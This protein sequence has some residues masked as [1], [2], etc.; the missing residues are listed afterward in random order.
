[1]VKEELLSII[2]PVYNVEKYLNRCIESIVNQTYKTIEIILIDDGSSDNS[3]YLCD[4]W[5]KKDSRIKVVHKQNGGVSSAR[6]QGIK[7]A[8]GEYV[9]FVDSD[10]YL[11]VDFCKNIMSE[12]SDDI[13]LVVSGFTIIDDS[14]NK[15]ITKV[16]ENIELNI[17]NSPDDFMNYLC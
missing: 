2:V 14:G 11:D 3:S 12:Y 7:V 9:Q 5:A 1:M 4:E 8:T 13:D 16:E 15:K 17:F 10:D 6:N